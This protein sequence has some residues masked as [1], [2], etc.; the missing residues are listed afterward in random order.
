MR[1][2]QIFFTFLLLLGCKNHA[3]KESNSQTVDN[4]ELSKPAEVSIDDIQS[5]MEFLTSDELKGR[6]SGTEGQIQAGNYIEDLLK[7]YNIKPF[8]ESYKD[9]FDIKNGKGFNVVG[10][11]EG[12]DPDLK[13]DLVILGAHYD[14]IGISKN[15]VEGD[16]IANGANDDASG[17]V[18][19][20]EFARYFSQLSNNK[21][22]I[23][24]ALFD[25]EEMGL[26]GSRHM[27]DRMKAE[28]Q[29][30]YAMINFELVGVPGKPESDL[31]YITGYEV[32]TLPQV[33]N[34]AAKDTVVGFS[35]MAKQY[36]LFKRSDNYG[37]YQAF[38]MPAHAIST[39]D[40]E[41]FPYYHTVDDEMDK[42]DLSHMKNFIDSMI[43]ALDGLINGPAG[44]LKMNE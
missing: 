33:L 15:A 1:F 36:Q 38:N 3:A 8:F 43:P 44:E 26:I 21:R 32:S 5:K 27:A 19:I 14:H 18:A 37:F 2:Y 40:M 23:I 29:T 17:T 22:S 7:S 4:P 31:S 34:N 28:G 41:L 42:L 13:S 25:A 16:S 10:Y 9:T 20:L 12:N 30:P 35:E 11:L 24:F 39:T 6:L